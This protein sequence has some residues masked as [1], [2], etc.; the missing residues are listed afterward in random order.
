MIHQ[1]PPVVGVSHVRSD[2]CHRVIPESSLR[3]VL[4]H[5]MEFGRTLA[6][7]VV[8]LGARMCNKRL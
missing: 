1:L 7:I 3:E 8:I 2:Q 4:N 6:F 5:G